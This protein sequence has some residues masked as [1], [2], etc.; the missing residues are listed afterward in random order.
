M[1][2]SVQTT[3]DPSVTTAPEA[4]KA[5]APADKKPTWAKSKKPS[6]KKA[7]PKASKKSAKKVAKKPVTKKAKA[8]ADP[9]KLTKVQ[10]A[11]LKTLKSGKPLTRNQL[12]EKTPCDPAQ[13]GVSVGYNDPDINA[14]PVHSGNL[15][16]R[17]AVRI[18]QHDI[19]GRDTITYTITATGKK[20]LE[21]N[22]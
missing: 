11:I 16:N 17:K 9:N 22:L 8:P 12:A 15:V 2:P 1:C 18:E 6:A 5:T 13:V 4:P 10:V 14:R 19:D 3:S 7:S 20:L 21:S